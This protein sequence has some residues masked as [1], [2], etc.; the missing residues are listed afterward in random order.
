MI[1]MVLLF[2]PLAGV[3]LFFFLLRFSLL[4]NNDY[5]DCRES[6]FTHCQ[7]YVANIHGKPLER[8]NTNENTPT[9]DQCKHMVRVYGCD[10]RELSFILVRRMCSVF[11]H[12]LKNQ[13]RSFSLV[14]ILLFQTTYFE[15]FVFFIRNI[16]NSYTG[17][18]Q[19]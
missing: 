7:R 4:E 17:L 3:F 10:Q 14:K 12:Q 19:N 1:A 9:F 6:F 18:V 16:G 15:Y 11:V 8:N 13:Q 5:R 2:A